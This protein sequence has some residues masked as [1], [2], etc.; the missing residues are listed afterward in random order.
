MVI[1]EAPETLDEVTAAAFTGLLDRRRGHTSIGEA[2]M[3][4]GVA[5][6]DPASPQP[7]QA[8]QHIAQQQPLAAEEADRRAQ[9][10]ANDEASSRVAHDEM[11]QAAKGQRGLP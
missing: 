5:E 8:A 4:V 1:L 9:A 7:T 2:A 3:M 10:T 6:A 11:L